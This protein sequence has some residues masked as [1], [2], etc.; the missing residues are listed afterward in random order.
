MTSTQKAVRAT[1]NLGGIQLNVF[2]LPD[3]SYG[4]SSTEIA[5]ILGLTSHR[6]VRQILTSAAMKANTI[7][8]LS[9]NKTAQYEADQEITQKQPKANDSIAIKPDIFDENSLNIARVSADVGIVNFIPLNL[10]MLVVNYEAYKNDNQRAQA[11]LQASLAEAIE[12]RADS[13]FN[14]QRA[15]QERNE[16]FATRY[17]G[18]LSRNFWTDT[19]DSY[20]KTHEVSDNYRKFIYINVSDIVNKAL[21]GLTSKQLREYYDLPN[22]RS[23][24]DML[25]SDTLKDVDMLEKAA[26][27]RVENTGSCPKQALKDM[28]ALIGFEPSSDR[29]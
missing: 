15:E 28:I 13:A 6:R 22:N 3:G 8:V 7:A 27:R 1:I 5:D 4:F 29:L 9:A 16:R 24:R 18:I 11:I 2:Q 20:C 17:D 10:L 12:R 14:I 19:I 23:V 25:P 21:F 26:A